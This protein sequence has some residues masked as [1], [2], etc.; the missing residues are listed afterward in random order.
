MVGHMYNLI[1][2]L[3][4][5]LTKSVNAWDR[6]VL[7]DGLIVPSTYSPHDGSLS[8]VHIVRLYS[9]MHNTWME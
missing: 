6:L 1:C 3:I 5:P 4:G 8:E 2:H 7:R 9:E